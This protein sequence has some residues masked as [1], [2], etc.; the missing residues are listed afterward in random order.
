MPV[1]RPSSYSAEIAQEICERLATGESVRGI[2]NSEDGLPTWQTVFSWLGKHPDFAE[3][4]ARAKELAAESI[5]EEIFDIADDTSGDNEEQEITPGVTATR[6]NPENIQRSKLRVDARKWYL[7]KIM[8]K[9][10]G[11]KVQQEVSGPDGGAPTLNVVIRSV[12]DK[13]KV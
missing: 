13:P 11:D 5:A 1:G 7:S 3:Q 10:Y 12:L 4:Y 6:L 2:C 8:P 9:K